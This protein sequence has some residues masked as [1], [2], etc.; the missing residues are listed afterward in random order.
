MAQPPVQTGEPGAPVEPAA[1]D[2]RW[3][4]LASTAVGGFVL[5][6]AA[7]GFLVLPQF[8]RANAGL[9]LWTAICRAA[10]TRF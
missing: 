5:L 2:K 4:L 3:R 10:A 9:D 6:G 8:Q 7:L 1:V